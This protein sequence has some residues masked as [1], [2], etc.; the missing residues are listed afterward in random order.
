MSVPTA[1][2]PSQGQN[3][4]LS[5]TT[6]SQVAITMKGTNQLR[7]TVKAGAGDLF[8]YTYSSTGSNARAATLADFCIVAGQSTTFTR[9]QSHDAVAYISD[10]TAVFKL[11]PGEGM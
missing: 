10:S 9:Y 4:N 8:I 1:F 3:Q 5:A 6:T 7:I 2:Q 11:I